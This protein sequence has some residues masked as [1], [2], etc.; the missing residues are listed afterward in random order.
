MWS[1]SGVAGSEASMSSTCIQWCWGSGKLRTYDTGACAKSGCATQTMRNAKRARAD[2]M[3]SLIHEIY[4]GHVLPVAATD[5][6]VIVWTSSVV[7]STVLTFGAP[8]DVPAVP[9]GPGGFTSPTPP[10]WAG[11]LLPVPGPFFL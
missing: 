3:R 9:A 1:S 10:D 8:F 5:A 2:R 11:C 6:T 4:L 7:S